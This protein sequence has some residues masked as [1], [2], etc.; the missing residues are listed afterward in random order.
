MQLTAES[1]TSFA[2][3]PQKL[4]P[5]RRHLMQALSLSC[6]VDYSVFVL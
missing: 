1:V 4:R 2:K 5:F 3:K 6:L